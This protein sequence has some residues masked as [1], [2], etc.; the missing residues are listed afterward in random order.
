MANAKLLSKLRSA[1]RICKISAV[2]IGVIGF[3]ATALYVSSIIPTLRQFQQGQTSFEYLSLLLPL[4]LFVVPTVFSVV[5]LYAIAVIMDFMG[6]EGKPEPKQQVREEENELDDNEVLEIV[7][8][9]ADM[10]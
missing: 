4:F 8:L 10:R 7:P 2:I 5:V 6:A 9:P 3:I 1:S